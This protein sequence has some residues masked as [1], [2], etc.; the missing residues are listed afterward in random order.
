MEIIDEMLTHFDRLGHREYGE[1]ITQL[2][3][4]LQTAALAPIGHYIPPSLR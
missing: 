2:E 1:S 4:A 3:H